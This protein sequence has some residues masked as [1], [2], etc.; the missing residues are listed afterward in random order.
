[1]I[2]STFAPPKYHI[3]LVGREETYW[4]PALNQST[5]N[6]QNADSRNDSHMSGGAVR[7]PRLDPLSEKCKD[8]RNL[9]S[10]R[11]VPSVVH[12]IFPVAV[13]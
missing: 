4:N 11:M 9:S 8:P 1:M 7:A 3:M 5:Q 13:L 12:T 6:A 2:R 10:M